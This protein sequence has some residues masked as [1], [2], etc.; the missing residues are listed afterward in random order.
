MENFIAK[1]KDD[2]F[3]KAISFQNNLDIKKNFGNNLRNKA[4]SSPL[5]DT[6]NFT[7]DFTETLKKVYLKYMGLDKV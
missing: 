5:F 7:K 4:L 1:N 2:Y 3:N 6:E